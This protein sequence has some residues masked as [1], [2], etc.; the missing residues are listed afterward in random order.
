[1]NIL[2]IPHRHFTD[3]VPDAYVGLTW[4]GQILKSAL[5]SDKKNSFTT[6]AR[7]RAEWGTRTHVQG[8]LQN[9]GPGS[10]MVAL[11]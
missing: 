5:P 11:L 2:E 8:G 3:H 4:E 9:Q 10:S 6:M 1:M 7:T